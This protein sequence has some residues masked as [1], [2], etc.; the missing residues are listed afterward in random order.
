MRLEALNQLL[1][2]LAPEVGSEEGGERPSCSL[3]SLLL[4]VQML[5]LSGSL[6]LQLVGP[7]AQETADVVHLLHYQVYSC[8][9][10]VSNPLMPRWRMGP[11]TGISFSAGPL[12]VY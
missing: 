12:P 10:S 1:A 3:K 7:E 4:T 9:Q 2:L 5:V 6:G 8:K 11:P